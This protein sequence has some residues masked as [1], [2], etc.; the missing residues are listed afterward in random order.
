MG[1]PSLAA[2]Q[3]AASLF[4]SWDVDGSGSLQI[5]E[6]NKVL[7]RGNDVSVAPRN[8]Y[9]VNI[10]SRRN[11]SRKKVDGAEITVEVNPDSFTARH[12]E[13]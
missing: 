3:A 13:I 1:A 7:R 2:W 10:S 4:R 12:A 11:W 8:D 9:C 5:R 6:L